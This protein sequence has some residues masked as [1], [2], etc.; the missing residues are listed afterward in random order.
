MRASWSRYLTYMTEIVQPVSEL[1]KSGSV[2]HVNALGSWVIY[3]YMQAG[4]MQREWRIFESM[5]SHTRVCIDESP[6]SGFWMTE[7]D[8][9]F[10][11]LFIFLCCIRSF[12]QATTL[13]RL[14]PRVLPL[15]GIGKISP[16]TRYIGKIHMARFRRFN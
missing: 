1:R 11:L 8:R 9:V 4:K 15:T 16:F 10:T 5:C 7:R 2:L 12:V 6:Y 3:I 14:V 13:F